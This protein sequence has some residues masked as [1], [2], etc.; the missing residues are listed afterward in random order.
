MNPLQEDGASAATYQNLTNERKPI[1]GLTRG[2]IV[3]RRD[4]VNTRP[5]ASWY[6]RLQLIRPLAIEWLR[7]TWGNVDQF[8]RHI[9][10]RMRRVQRVFSPYDKLS[11]AQQPNSGESEMQTNGNMYDRLERPA[12][13][14]LPSRCQGASA[15]EDT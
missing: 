14:L 6:N 13:V 4:Y 12:P 11:K 1:P 9:Y 3:H 5:T 2:V 10:D 7:N 8:G 15:T